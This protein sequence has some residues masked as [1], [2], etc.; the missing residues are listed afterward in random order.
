MAIKIEK[1]QTEIPIEIGD[2]KF[3]FDVTDESIQRFRE[4]AIKIQQELEVINDEEEDFNKTKDILKKGFDVILGDGAFE[5]V[6]QMTPSIPYL[7]N[8]FIQLVDGLTEELNDIGAFQER[9]NKYLRK[10]K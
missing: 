2:L 5:R 4:N 10:K 6:Y 1:K 3:A 8:Y 7:L 9:A